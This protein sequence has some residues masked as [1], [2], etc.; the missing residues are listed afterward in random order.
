MAVRLDYLR[1]A[2]GLAAAAQRADATAERSQR[3]YHLAAQIRVRH[4]G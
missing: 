1:L 2:P 4:R 3:A